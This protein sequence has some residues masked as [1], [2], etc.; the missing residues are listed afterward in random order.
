MLCKNFLN[1]L[2]HTLDLVFFLVFLWLFTQSYPSPFSN[3]KGCFQ[4][5]IWL[6]TLC[7]REITYIL[8]QLVKKIQTL[9]S[10][11]TRRREMNIINCSSLQETTCISAKYV[12]W[13]PTKSIFKGKIVV[14]LP[15]ICR[16]LDLN[17]AVVVSVPGDLVLVV[18]WRPL[19]VVEERVLEA[20]VPV[21]HL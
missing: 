16:H 14:V 9:S 7:Y 11:S 15:E 13:W 6:V 18:V 21:R 5:L 2:H 17:W 20:S 3:S 19:D 1:I 12:W 8:L 10:V 4:S